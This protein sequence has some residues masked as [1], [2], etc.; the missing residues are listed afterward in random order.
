MLIQ[1]Q[2]HGH[3]ALKRD[4]LVEDQE[5]AKSISR[6]NRILEDPT[7]VWLMVIYWPPRLTAVD[8]PTAGCDS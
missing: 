4:A 7:E 1:Y 2:V 3:L 5:T 6:A 8:A